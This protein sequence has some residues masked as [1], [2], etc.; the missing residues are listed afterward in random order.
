MI[1]RVHILYF[2]ADRHYSRSKF[3]G[4]MNGSPTTQETQRRAK[5]SDQ[6]RNR[7]K[8]FTNAKLGC[9]MKSRRVQP[10][11]ESKRARSVQR[12]RGC[13]TCSMHQDSSV[14]T[15]WFAAG[16]GGLWCQLL[17]ERYPGATP[18]I[19]RVLRVCFARTKYHQTR[20][21]RKILHSKGFLLRSVSLRLQGWTGS[22]I[23][24]NQRYDITL[25][26]SRAPYS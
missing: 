11:E 7:D 17:R 6:A 3:N 16:S 21:C 1:P 4:Q 22:G 2:V 20:F 15:N 23:G 10:H 24:G 14:R 19:G 25:C 12:V 9:R 8:T 18:R 26:L 5:A 13:E